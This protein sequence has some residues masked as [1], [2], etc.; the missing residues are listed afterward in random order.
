MVNTMVAHCH[1]GPL[2]GQDF[3]VDD[4]IETLTA[5]YALDGMMFVAL[6][7]IEKIC[8]GHAEAFHAD[9]KPATLEQLMDY[10]GV[11]R[12]PEHA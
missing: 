2:D 1:T 6:Y 4:D 11:K 12:S 7:L 8:K 10:A 9:Y 3:D 5:W